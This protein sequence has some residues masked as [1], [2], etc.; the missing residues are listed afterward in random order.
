MLFRVF[1]SDDDS[2]GNFSRKIQ[3]TSLAFGIARW[4]RE[5]KT[6]Q[7]ERNCDS[8]FPY[9]SHAL[10]ESSTYTTGRTNR[11]RTG[12][13]IFP[14]TRMPSTC[15]MSLI[16]LMRPMTLLVFH[17]TF[18]SLIRGVPKTSHFTRNSGVLISKSWLLIS[19]SLG[20]CQDNRDNLDELEFS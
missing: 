18:R 8:R 13:I 4:D 16:S 7:Y 12:R 14:F 5:P 17:P 1:Y 3:L 15:P 2:K 10:W 19:V 6:A 20:A 11:Q 9:L